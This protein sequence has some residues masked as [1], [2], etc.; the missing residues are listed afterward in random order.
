MSLYK[1]I[2]YFFCS[3]CRP[4]QSRTVRFAFPLVLGVVGIVSALA[5]TSSNQTFIEVVPSKTNIRAGEIIALDVFV[6]A[7]KP[8]NAVNISLAIPETQLKVMGIDTGESVITLWTEDPHVENGKVILSGGTF[9]KGFLGRHLIAT[10]NARAVETGLAYVNVSD[11]MLLAGDGSAT[12]IKAAQNKAEE[13]TLYIASADGLF[14]TDNPVEASSFEAQAQ[15][16]IVSDI[17][18][19]GKVTLNDISRFMTAWHSKTI[20]YDFNGDGKMTFRDFAIIL[21]HSFLR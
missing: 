20:I 6:S 21:A 13:V 16:Y 1:K 2:L 7:H 9:R 15:I 3:T 10:I 4:N 12:K 14:A 11:S 19:D 8:V 18:G 17:D 5:V